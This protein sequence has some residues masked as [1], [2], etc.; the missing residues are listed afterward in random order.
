[1]PRKKIVKQGFHLKFIP[2]GRIEDLKTLAHNFPFV[3]DE[4]LALCKYIETYSMI[5]ERCW[6]INKPFVPVSTRI[7]KQKLSTTNSGASR[8]LN[9]LVKHNF[10]IRDKS[11]FK[12]AEHAWDYKPVYQML[13]VVTLDKVYLNK[14]TDELLSEYNYKNLKGELKSYYDVLSKIKLSDDVYRYMSYVQSYN[15]NDNNIE[16]ISKADMLCIKGDSFV[17]YQNLS[18]RE[19]DSSVPLQ[20]IGKVPA[21]FIPVYKLL[22]GRFRLSRP[23]PNSRV[24][25]NITNLSRE[26]RKFLRLNDKP[27]IGFD[28]ANSQPLI[29]AVAFRRYSESTYDY[30]KPDILDYQKNCEMGRFYEYFM[31]LNGI[32]TTCEIARTEFKGMFFGKVFYTKEVE[33]ENHLK[34]QF[35][36]KY[37]T[38]YEAILQIKGG[39]YSSK[40]KDFPAIMT[41]IETFIMFN[42]N[43]KLIEAGYD[44]VNIFD[45]LYSDSDEA[46]SMAKELVVAAFD[47]CGGIKP[48][49]KD[50]SYRKQ[51]IPAPQA[52]IIPMIYKQTQQQTMEPVEAPKSVQE[53]SAL[54]PQPSIVEWSEYRRIHG[55]SI[56]SKS[57]QELKR[58]YNALLMAQRKT[59]F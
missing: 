34:T 42:T 49:L 56:F 53:D 33:K 32:D 16:T 58:D 31:E 50:I 29:A 39:L 47:E 51:P 59:A 35:K 44:V 11:S 15:N 5:V 43:I 19:G 52:K 14:K 1:M 23:I 13:D 3:Q 9:D 22:A 21:Q 40:Y 12:I 6:N 55:S 30:I 4:H 17:P 2:V 48:M 57:M 38:C 10:L 8:I 54:N 41:E 24:Y 37:P 45:S 28:I 27:L 7:L 18:H 26:Y 25:T 46:I 20:I 36:E